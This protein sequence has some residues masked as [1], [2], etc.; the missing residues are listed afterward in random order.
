MFAVSI[1][2]IHDSVTILNI[3]HFTSIQGPAII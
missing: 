1:D 3:C 2:T